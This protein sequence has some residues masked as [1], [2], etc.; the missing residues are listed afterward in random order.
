M[1]SVIVPV[2]NSKLYLSNCLKSILN[3][4]F[5]QYE[6]LII[7]DGSDDGSEIICDEYKGQD[8]RIRVFHKINQGV[9]SAR[10]LGIV[11]A[12]G[13]YITFVDSDDIIKPNYLQGLYESINYTNS[14]IAICKYCV[15]K[16]GAEIK[17]ID[18]VKNNYIEKSQID[19]LSGLFSST[20]F[21]TVWGKLYRSY[22]IKDTFFI[23]ENIGEDVEF[24]SRIYLKSERFVYLPDELYI[25]RDNFLSTTRRK[26]SLNN[27][28][29]LNCYFMAYTNM[30]TENGLYQS[31]AL[32]RLYK[33]ILST[34]YNCTSE[35]KGIL[36]DKIR[37]ILSQISMD[38]LK[39]QH[40]HLKNK[41]TLLSFYHLPFLYSFYRYWKER[42]GKKKD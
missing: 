1:I 6:L 25:W 20:E 11:E 35:F 41:I 36:N 16:E 12:K 4:T 17:Q 21:M 8:S 3:Q 26:F 31:F 23:S 14:D 9:S 30:P 42:E 28:T 40:V 10:N 38:F 7:D 27:V 34:R 22:L 29:A 18:N 39:N 5:S 13:D 33:V 2:Y 37:E 15:D 24:N 32:Q 19:I